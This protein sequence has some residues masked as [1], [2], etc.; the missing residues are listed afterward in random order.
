LIFIFI[1]IKIYKLVFGAFVFI[2][3]KKIYSS[4]CCSIFVLSLASQA[5]ETSIDKSP[6]K[7]ERQAASNAS[8]K[9]YD[10]LFVGAGVSFDYSKLS[11]SAN[12]EFKDASQ[13]INGTSLCGAASI[14][15]QCN[16]CGAFSIGIEAGLD[17][18]SQ[19]NKMPLGGVLK[20][21]SYIVLGQE[22]RRALLAS[23]LR[24][25]SDAIRAHPLHPSPGGGSTIVSN[26]PWQNLLRT[27]R[28]LGNAPGTADAGGLPADALARQFILSE[29][30]PRSGVYNRATY[31]TFMVA[32]DASIANAQLVDF[33]P[34][35]IESLREFGERISGRGG[36]EALLAGAR[37]IRDFISESLPPAV[38][39]I[40]QN[41]AA[42][43]IGTQPGGAAGPW[44]GTRYGG[45]DS[46]TD[47][48][49]NVVSEFL[50]GPSSATS[51]F[52]TIA[53]LNDVGIPDGTL[54]GA[55]A[56]E[57]LQ[58]AINALLAIYDPAR[59]NFALP[60]GMSESEVRNT[61]KNE[62]TFGVCPNLA[63]KFGYF[64]KEINGLMYVK[65]GA[66]MLRGKAATS[67]KLL[68][69]FSENFQKVV[70]FFA[71]GFN[72]LIDNNWGITVELSHSVK[73]KKKLRDLDIFGYKISNEI[74][75]SKSNVRIMATYRFK[76]E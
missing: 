48:A 17:F 9:D 46:L 10:G 20:H 27:F 70:P 30:S 6:E 66:A 34:R 44:A 49:A 1:N 75:L 21:D 13:S 33:M 8:A 53:D 71:I 55:N 15:Y 50:D 16:V 40:L 7:I 2:M 52:A 74:E 60:H 32:N 65:L 69:A 39:T 23:M 26:A 37:G 61:I 28:Y 11:S 56:A 63:L 38:G 54:Q 67:S 24:S 19:T 59:I 29:T 58:T 12:G 51:Q 57:Q 64:F 68:G 3:N 76:S 73:G 31:A 4:L 18:G 25:I 45:A 36:D 47:A 72:K 14:G 41:I 43:D 35:A 42:I 5:K 62:K 22:H